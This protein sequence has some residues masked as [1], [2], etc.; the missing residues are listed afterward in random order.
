M[1]KSKIYLETTIFNFPFADDAPQYRA[2]ALRLFDMIKAGKYDPY[3][4]LYTT[5]ELEATATKS[6]RFKMLNLIPDYD[7][8]ILQKIPEAERLAGLYLAGG[9]VPIG[10]YADALHIAMTAVYGLDFIVSLNFQ[11]I[12]REKT[13]RIT[14]EINIREGYKAIGI[15]KPSEVLDS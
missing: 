8:K 3:T 1:A 4:S 12:V 10:F 2:D 5:E 15:Y 11:H 7:V 13:I 6:R 14:G 9:A